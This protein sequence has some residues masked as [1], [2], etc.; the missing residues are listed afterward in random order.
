M[1]QQAIEL[2]VHV[3]GVP[4][5]CCILQSELHQRLDLRLV[6]IAPGL[7]VIYPRLGSELALSNEQWS[8]EAGLAA[9]MKFATAVWTEAI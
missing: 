2:W 5:H 8:F 4:L 6:T 1:R 7:R 3:L 9:Q